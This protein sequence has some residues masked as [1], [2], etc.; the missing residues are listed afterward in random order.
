MQRDSAQSVGR[1]RS[2]TDLLKVV[3]LTLLGICIAQGSSAFVVGATGDSL[4]NG[5]FGRVNPGID[6][7]YEVASGGTRARRYVGLAPDPYQNDEYHD[8]RDDVLSLSPDVIV[9]MLG[10]NDAVQPDPWFDDEYVLHITGVLEDF[11]NSGAR[12]ILATPIPITD[13]DYAEA[14]ERLVS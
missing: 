4:T 9:F 3:V 14:E 1:N 13:P 8:F 10:T 5:Y 12:V 7:W 6:T 2:A 11:A